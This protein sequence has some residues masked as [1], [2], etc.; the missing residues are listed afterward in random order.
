MKQL[1][2]LRETVH[3]HHHLFSVL[4][5][6][7]LHLIVGFFKAVSFIFPTLRWDLVPSFVFTV[8]WLPA[9]QFTS[10]ILRPHPGSK[11]V[12][13]RPFLRCQTP[14]HTVLSDTSSSVTTLWFFFSLASQNS[15]FLPDFF[16]HHLCLGPCRL[17]I[18][19]DICHLPPP[20]ALHLVFCMYHHLP[21][22]CSSQGSRSGVFKA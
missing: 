9:P 4:F 22:A 13:L 8:P 3:H 20:V 15:S 17:T 21:S 6:V 19:L 11:T 14:N 16:S 7:C 2:S 5:P 10:F 12:I 18:I 1:F